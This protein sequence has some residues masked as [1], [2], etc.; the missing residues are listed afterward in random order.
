MVIYILLALFV[1]FIIS[2]VLY[3]DFKW[4]I[5]LAVD[6]SFLFSYPKS[7]NNRKGTVQLLLLW[8]FLYNDFS[9]L[10]DMEITP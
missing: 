7:K 1:S 6:A 2:S 9:D 10:I 8:L 4:W 3:I 5:T